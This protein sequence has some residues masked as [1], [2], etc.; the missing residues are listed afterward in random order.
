MK[1]VLGK[2]Q[3]EW[4]EKKS[5]LQTWEY[6]DFLAS[7]GRDIKR[8]SYTLDNETIDIQQINTGLPLGKKTTYI[9]HA[10]IPA[11]HIDGVLDDLKKEGFAFVRL[12]SLADLDLS[13]YNTRK[14]INRQPQ[15]TWILPLE[16]SMDDLYANM[17]RK[18]RYNIR[19][20]KKKGV[21]IEQK[22]DYQTFATLNAL[23]TKRQQYTSISD[24][25]LKEVLELPHVYQFN[26]IHDNDILA[27]AI[28]LEYKDTLYYLIGASSD[29]KRSVMA[30]YALH[31]H[32]I[33]WAMERG[34]ETYD[35]W[36][37]APT[38]E[39]GKENT[40][41]HHEYCW[42]R[43]HPL[44]GVARFK[45]GFGG[46][47]YSHPDAVDIIFDK[48]YYTLFSI[49]QRMRGVRIAGQ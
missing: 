34:L 22:N 24:T 3:S 42:D 17:H 13:A 21:E 20:A 8:K 40:L 7:I 5:F 15:Y 4:G 14:T 19:L 25:Y 44:S 32:I 12:E 38:G 9:P 26:A 35:L 27:T 18:T 16:G 37:T 46:H 23:T 36:G 43:T 2:T 47:L 33:A 28:T 10:D 45:A 11:S 48:T 41:C 39:K 31:E 49:Y 29:E 1:I 30:P 6:G